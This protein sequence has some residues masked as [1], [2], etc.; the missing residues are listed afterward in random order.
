M[1]MLAKVIVTVL[2]TAISGHSIW[3][4]PMHGVYDE[5]PEEGQSTPAGSHQGRFLSL[6]RD[7]LIRIKR[8]LRRLPY[9][10]A[11][12]D[13]IRNAATEAERGRD[14]DVSFDDIVP[15][16]EDRLLE[17]WQFDNDFQTTAV[18]YMSTEHTQSN[19][20]LLSNTNDVPDPEERNQTQGQLG[21]FA[22]FHA[23]I[24]PLTRRW[25]WDVLTLNNI[26]TG[27]LDRPDAPERKYSFSK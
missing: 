17:M 6:S 23:Y 9:R 5:Y 26:S 27:S 25:L 16:P 8:M 19:I 15:D 1:T 21:C 24:G 12:L 14:V 20:Q 3:I 2:V 22:D 11:L 10:N 4:H 18:E 7:Q 13:A